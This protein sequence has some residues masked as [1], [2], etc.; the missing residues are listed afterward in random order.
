MPNK[1][2]KYFT[3]ARSKFLPVFLT[4]LKL[5]YKIFSTWNGLD[6]YINVYVIKQSHVKFHNI[7]QLFKENTCNKFS[8]Y[9]LYFVHNPMI[10]EP[11]CYQISFRNILSTC[12][13]SIHLL[14]SVWVIQSLLPQMHTHIHMSCKHS[15]L[16]IYTISHIQWELFCYHLVY[17]SFSIRSLWISGIVLATLARLS[18]LT[19]TCMCVLTPLETHTVAWPIFHTEIRNLQINL[20][21]M[22]FKMPDVPDEFR[23]PIQSLARPYVRSDLEF[24]EC[25]SIEVTFPVQPLNLRIFCE[26]VMRWMPRW[27]PRC[28]V[29]IGLGNA[30]VLPS[31]KPLSWAIVEQYICHH[32]ASLRCN[33]LRCV[34]VYI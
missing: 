14:K 24:H 31:D 7:Y 28:Q 2:H 15:N 33:E 19:L 21:M 22:S 30:L 23:S 20:S 5:K 16:I 1:I 8:A 3:L 27:M 29:N 32:M 18:P 34:C 17:F 12:R 10:D 26:I 11:K 13:L 6:R 9:V 4:S 25:L